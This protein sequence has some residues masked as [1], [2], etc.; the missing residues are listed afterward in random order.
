MLKK[1]L[2]KEFKST[3]YSYKDKEGYIYELLNMESSE[4]RDNDKYIG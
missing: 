4:E 1:Q 3:E 2:F